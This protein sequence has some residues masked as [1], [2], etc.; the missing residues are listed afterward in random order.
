[1]CNSRW[2]TR[3]LLSN[4]EKKYTVFSLYFTHRMGDAMKKSVQNGTLYGSM[5]LFVFLRCV[6]I[7]LPLSNLFT[8]F[9]TWDSWKMDIKI[10]GITVLVTIQ[11]ECFILA[12]N[13]CL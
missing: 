6:Q 9:I 5:P 12:F 3:E 4:N 13:K 11:F 1:M 10:C 2:A 7:L 8:S